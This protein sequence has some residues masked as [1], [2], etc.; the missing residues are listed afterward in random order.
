MI[1]EIASTIWKFSR[2]SVC[3]IAVSAS[4]AISYVHTAHGLDINA[5]LDTRLDSF[6]AE[7]LAGRWV[8]T[9]VRKE[10]KLEN[11]AG[12]EVFFVAEGGVSSGNFELH[13]QKRRWETISFT[14]T[15]G[16]SVKAEFSYYPRA[17]EINSDIPNELRERLEGVL[18][19]QIKLDMRGPEHSPFVRLAFTPGEVEWTF[20][21]QT[22]DIAD[23]DV[24]GRGPETEYFY[25]PEPIIEVANKPSKRV[26]I[27]G[28]TDVS[29][30]REGETVTPQVFSMI[31]GQK[32]FPQAYLDEDIYEKV[33]GKL[34]LNIKGLTSGATAQVTLE[35]RGRPESAEYRYGPSLSRVS[36]PLGRAIT[37]GNCKTSHEYYYPPFLSNAW[38]ESFILTKEAQATREKG[39]CIPFSGV[40]S[41]IVEFDI[42]DGALYRL[43]WFERWEHFALAEYQKTAERMVKAIENGGRSS[44]SDFYIEMIERYIKLVNLP[45][46]SLDNK[47]AIASLYFGG[48]AD[49]KFGG[50]G[51]YYS[52]IGSETWDLPKNGLMF[53][54]DAEARKANSSRNIQL[55]S[56]RLFNERENR[57]LFRVDKVN[58]HK[59]ARLA[60][61]GLFAEGCC[62]D[63]NTLAWMERSL[64]DRAILF[65]EARKWADAGDYMVKQGIPALYGLTAAFNPAAKAYTLF[66]QEDVFGNKVSDEQYWLNVVDI[67]AEFVMLGFSAYDAMSP[68]RFNNASG[69][70]GKIIS[71][72]TSIADLT[73][74]SKG[75]FRARMNT[76]D[77]PEAPVYAFR[78]ARSGQTQIMRAFDEIDD[79]LP[80]TIEP[81][82]RQQV[83][84]R[85]EAHDLDISVTERVPADSTINVRVVAQRDTKPP[86]TQILN[87]DNPQAEYGGS[88]RIADD[89]LQHF[90]ST[91]SNQSD[92]TAANYVVWRETGKTVTERQSQQRFVL[93]MEG[94]SEGQSQMMPGAFEY[95]RTRPVP[96]A[97]FAQ[98]MRL[99][100]IE[101][102]VVNLR[103]QLDLAEIRSLTSAGWTAEV[104]INANSN[105]LRRVY[106]EQIQDGPYGLSQRIS[107]FDPARG[108]VIEMDSDAFFKI[109]KVDDETRVNIYKARHQEANAGAI[110]Q[111][112]YD[113]E[114]SQRLAEFDGTPRENTYYRFADGDETMHVYLGDA[115]ADGQINAVFEAPDH[116]GQVYRVSKSNNPGQVVGVVNDLY[117]RRLLADPN[118]NADIIEPLTVHQTKIVANT[119]DRVQVIERIDRFKGTLADELLEKQG[120][121]YTK[122]QQ[123]AYVAAIREIN[124]RGAIYIDGHRQNISFIKLPGNDRWKI[125][126]FDP[127]GIYPVK[128][129]DFA[130]RVRNAIDLQNTAFTPDT[131]VLKAYGDNLAGE[132]AGKRQYAS[133]NFDHKWRI[134]IDQMR[135][136]H[137][138]VPAASFDT[139]LP[140]S[141][142]APLREKGIRDLMRYSPEQI[143][144]WQLRGIRPN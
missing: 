51:F 22:G 114:R 21:E 64:V 53:L 99:E 92:A 39:N 74:R 9:A 57:N 7:R 129:V 90:K 30:K 44:Q 122:G 91:D 38:I 109:A 5:A 101:T 47:L 84:R 136:L 75:Q 61:E 133:F 55:M 24:I 85:A 138:A 19:W 32:I 26:E 6:Q 56:L 3:A 118:I 52:V 140:A 128:G 73:T 112:K 108:Q 100:G 31:Q 127:G 110:Q 115:I 97:V 59:D 17:D 89:S 93:A 130:A 49:T 15:E 48:S 8:E 36:H 45:Q 117:G 94:M 16:G 18:E 28:F 35:T 69:F 10:G 29:E 95:G 98:R 87:P 142:W 41:E 62:T 125:Q 76:A 58:Y 88:A 34:T 11:G 131:T 141:F 63:P 42:G 25:R 107:F 79:A 105:H 135:A 68:F 126:I 60:A 96:D 67:A 14:N 23:F 54:T 144:T 43:Q 65:S 12:S 27:L 82:Q 139:F 124:K 13:T 46:L 33:G 132:L 137:P 37:L 103:G 72:D 81:A 71:G 113:F 120:G 116:P 121:T 2:K 143:E 20:A 119:A 102:V 40:S 106:I 104:K 78:R 50:A 83:V 123:L 66:T 134:D 70:G 111:A 4:L 77:I 80:I 86:A 1:S